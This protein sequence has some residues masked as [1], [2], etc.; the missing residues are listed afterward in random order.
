[1][2]NIFLTGLSA[3]TRT[4]LADLLAAAVYAPEDWHGSNVRV[5]AVTR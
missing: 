3:T 5:L 2:S 4:E 1:M